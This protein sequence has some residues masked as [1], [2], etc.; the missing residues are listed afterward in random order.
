MFSS[1]CRF[2]GACWRLRMTLLVAFFRSLLWPARAALKGGF[3][4]PKRRDYAAANGTIHNGYS[5][6]KEIYNC[7]VAAILPT[8]TPIK[9]TNGFF[10]KSL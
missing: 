10:L 8:M 4:T 3:T 9:E 6:D 5:G 7:S 2:F 1:K